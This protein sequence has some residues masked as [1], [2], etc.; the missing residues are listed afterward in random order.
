MSNAPTAKILLIGDSGVGKSSLMLRFTSDTFN[1]D[2]SATIGIDFRVKLVD[3]RDEE[4]GA[5]HQMAMQIWDTAG[6]ERFRTLTSSYY[7]SARAVALVFDVTRRSSFD[8]IQ[9]W[10]EEAQTFCGS[11]QDVVYLLVGN[12]V[13]LVEEGEGSGAPGAVTKDEARRFAKEHHMLCAFTSAKT[14]IGVAQAFEE[15]G[16]HVYDRL[17]GRDHSAGSR[18][19]LER[20]GPQEKHHGRCC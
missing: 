1:E 20:T 6:Q 11:N 4:T 17:Q 12:K 19:H 5:S 15:L 14:K 9:R 16:R 8:N 2:I 18:V 13:D 3:V 10:K 7:R